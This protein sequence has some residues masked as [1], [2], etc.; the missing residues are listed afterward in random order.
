MI[1]LLARTAQTIGVVNEDGRGNRRTEGDG[2]CYFFWDIYFYCGK[3][4][5]RDIPSYYFDDLVIST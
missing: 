3:V 2:C 1:T 5:S 4:L